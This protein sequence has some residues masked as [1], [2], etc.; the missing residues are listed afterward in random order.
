[1]ARHCKIFLTFGLLLLSL[2]SSAIAQQRNVTVF[3][4]PDGDSSNKAASTEFVQK[5]FAGG[6]SLTIPAPVTGSVTSGGIPYFDST[7]QLSS[8]ALLTAQKLMIGGGA[9]AAPSTIDVG[10][11]CTFLSPDLTCTKLNGVSP[12]ALYPLNVGT[13]LASSG[14]NLN[15]K[16]AAA[17]EIGGVNSKTCP[18]G[19]AI[20]TI[21]TDGSITCVASGSFKIP[22]GRLVLAASTCSGVTSIN[23]GDV[24][25]ATVACYVPYNGSTVV[26]NSAPFSFSTLTLDLT[27]A[28]S[29]SLYDIFAVNHSG[30][31]ALC[32]G[33]AWSSST[34]RSA[35]IAVTSDG[36][37]DN[38]DTLS[39]CHNG[40]TDYG[41]F[42]AGEAT[43]LGTVYATSA[44][45]SQ[46]VIKP[47]AASGGTNNVLG[48]CNA[49]NRHRVS[50]L[51]HDSTSSWVAGTAGTWATFNSGG[52][53]SGLNNRIT[54]V[55]CLSTDEVNWTL[56]AATSYT[57]TGAEAL[58]VAVCVDC[59][60]TATVQDQIFNQSG[61]TAGNEGNQV[62]AFGHSFAGIGLHYYQAM[63]NGQS[64]GTGMTVL[65]G[66]SFGGFFLYTD[67]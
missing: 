1:M 62:I 54:V 22:N 2:C 10:G 5:A 21:G 39:S 13:G 18:A 29:G 53:G 15:L 66:N 32:W 50:A 34:A 56:S 52:T 41:S 40:S 24:T 12:G 7:T 46:W 38:S 17:A 26:I 44:G 3:T 49:Y 65:G 11:D 59:T 36:Y 35:A 63:E 23:A 30:S 28:G 4:A 6:S 60:T 51:E 14:G 19:Q 64:T 42:T 58:T 61:L 48:V 31:A 25:S 8:S 33:P 43:Y 16:P 37:Y 67:N 20:G 57:S 55:N 9:G 45:T 27:G 47:A